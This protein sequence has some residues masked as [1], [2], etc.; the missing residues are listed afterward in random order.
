M[1][2]FATLLADK[3]Y[4]FER[5]LASFEALDLPRRELHWIL[6]THRI[7]RK[8]EAALRCYVKH[9]TPAW[10]KVTWLT[11]A[12]PAYPQGAGANR[13]Q[14]IASVFETV[15][16]T[17]DKDWLTVL[18]DDILVPGDGWRKLIEAAE[19]DPD[20]W[21]VSACQPSRDERGAVQVWDIVPTHD[22]RPG[23]QWARRQR[24]FADEPADG[25]E[26]VGCTATGFSVF[27]PEF[28]TR[29]RFHCEKRFGGQDLAAGLDLYRARKRTL[30]HW[31]VKCVHCA[32][33]GDYV[34][35]GPYTGEMRT[36]APAWRATNG[37]ADIAVVVSTYPAY[38]RW[39]REAISSVDS[40]TRQPAEKILVCDR[41]PEP[42]ADI[43]PEW[44]IIRRDDGHVGPG[45]N[46][47]LREI[48]AP[49]VVWLDGD[50][51]LA[52]DYCALQAGA[53]A[54]ASERVGVVYPSLHYYEETMTSVCARKTF[55]DFDPAELRTANYIPT[56]SCWRVQALQSIGG[57]QIAP[58]MDDWAN[59]MRITALGWRGVYNPA[60]VVR[61]RKHAGALSGGCRQ[62]ETSWQYRRFG[63]VTLLAGDRANLCE[64]LAWLERA[65]LPPRCGLYCLDDSGDAEFGAAL[66]DGLWRLRDRFTFFHAQLP[67]GIA[68]IDGLHAPHYR[69][70]QLYAALL[71][72]VLGDADLVLFLEDDIRPPVD[73]LARLHEAFWPGR[74]P[75]VGACAACYPSRGGDGTRVSLSSAQDCWR[76]NVTWDNVQPGLNPIG[77]VPGG[78]VLF[79]GSALA[80]ACLP[81][82]FTL[83]PGA[84][85][86]GWDGHVSRDLRAAGWE[87]L[88]HGD[89]RCE[90]WVRDYQTGEIQRLQPPGQETEACD[91]TT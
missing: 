45:R 41:G 56:P 21:M 91:P 7:S 64:W 22:P 58:Q 33:E 1:Q 68:G 61:V 5:W 13:R 84:G 42:P 69:V 27:R 10:G 23:W 29:F 52:P 66:R 16:R 79:R 35:P 9:H 24:H 18:E 36:I 32:P 48:T 39:L 75:K 49:W 74:V 14:A 77:M 82:R 8:T 71:I 31:G 89:V 57:W 28:V 83:G 86:T 44:K 67:A 51:M 63:I 54:T 20:A 47:A 72:R 65:E 59:A 19:A 80:D 73:A 25:V 11:I 15:R 2:T 60:A 17:A 76:A 78:C 38:A 40:Q 3:P 34:N 50:D 62:G 26:A 87:L 85:A 55:R 46:A 53:A 88:Y 4:C 12:T 81:M 6:T 43:G 90:H 30:V 37:A 70:A